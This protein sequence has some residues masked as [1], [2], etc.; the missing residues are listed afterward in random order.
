MLLPQ[1]SN[2]AIYFASAVVFSKAVST[3]SGR[4]AGI[5]VTAVRSIANSACDASW[6]ESVSGASVVRKNNAHLMKRIGVTINL[7]ATEEKVALADGAPWIRNQIEFHGLTANAVPRCCPACQ[8]PLTLE[9]YASRPAW[10]ELFY[11]RHSLRP[12]QRVS[13]G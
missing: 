8:A 9:W 4:L 5:S 13:T 1:R 12:T 11:G 3:T 2:R 10:H 6:P 7:S